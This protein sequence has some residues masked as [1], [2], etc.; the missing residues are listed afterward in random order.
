[1]RKRRLPVGVTLTYYIPIHLRHDPRPEHRRWRYLAHV[2]HLGKCYA[3]GFDIEAHGEAEAFRLA[4]EWRER[5]ASRLKP[6]G[7]C[8]WRVGR[9]GKRSAEGVAHA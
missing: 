9:A 7:M 8:A 2:G 5:M 3:K 1:M 4:R 6:G